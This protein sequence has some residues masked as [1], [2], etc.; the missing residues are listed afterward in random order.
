M[1]ANMAKYAASS[2][3][4]GVDEVGRGPLAGAVIAA[5]VILD[6]DKP[7]MGL[8]DSKKLSD[9]RRRELVDEIKVNA[10][11]YAIGRVEV[12]EIDT[13][14]IH[15]ASLLA[16][17]RAVI[18]LAEDYPDACIKQV[19]VDGSFRPLIP[20]P[21]EAVVAGDLSE[22]VISAASILAKVYRD[23]EMNE[24][25]LSFPG[26]GLAQHKGYPT[27]MHLAALKKLGV[28]SIH[29]RSYGPV[30][31]LILNRD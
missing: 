13:L 29:R 14:N 17:Q 12:A 7:I 25:D 19:I 21:C 15:H 2:S 18:A 10:L 3:L 31:A 30:K 5:A 27:K 8:K 9:K 24:L 1:S 11:A 20:Y 26:Y 6:P 28:S 23:N 16:M 4:V 22:P